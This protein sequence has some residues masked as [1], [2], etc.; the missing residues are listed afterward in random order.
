MIGREL[1]L[2]AALLIVAVLLVLC[3]STAQAG[4][5]MST[6]G[7]YSSASGGSALVPSTA[8]QYQRELTRVVQQEWGLGGPV[9][10]HAAQIHQESGWRAGVDSRVGAQGL[11]QFMPGTSS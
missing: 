4:L 1:A 8:Q 9:A 10:L 11:A 6:D 7:R 5:I 3:A 2:K